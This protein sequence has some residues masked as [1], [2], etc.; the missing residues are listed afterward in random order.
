LPPTTRSLPPE[1]PFVRLILSSI[2]AGAS[3]FVVRGIAGRFLSPSAAG[4]AA[5]CAA[6]LAM[7]PLSRLNRTAPAWAHWAGGGFVLLVFWLMLIFSR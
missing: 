3:W 7:Y 4:L 1:F 5:F 2:A 6:W